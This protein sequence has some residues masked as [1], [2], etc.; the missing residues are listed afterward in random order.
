MIIVETGFL[1]SVDEDQ[2]EASC[3]LDV[4][5]EYIGL[6]RSRN[7]FTIWPEVWE[8]LDGGTNDAFDIA[9]TSI[10]DILASDL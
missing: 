4:K 6:S 1:V 8:R 9:Q 10:R 2:V 3:G 5:I 7:E